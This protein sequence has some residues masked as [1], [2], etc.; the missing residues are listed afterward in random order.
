MQPAYRVGR[1]ASAT[2]P[3]RREQV[4]IQ[5]LGMMMNIIV[6]KL[7]FMVIIVIFMVIMMIFI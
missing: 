1:E 4:F 5:I 6:I 3:R 2:Q 7:M